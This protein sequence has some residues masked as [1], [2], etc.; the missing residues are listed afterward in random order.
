[1]KAFISYSSRNRDAV[2]GLAKDLDGAL[3]TISPS[4]HNAVWFD[5]ALV[6]GQDWWNTILDHLMNCDV[7]VFALSPNSISS[8]ACNRE[9]NYAHELNKRILPI[10]ITG[11][12]NSIDLP[13][14]LQS[15]QWINYTRQD[16]VAYQ[17]LLNALIELPAPEPLPDPLPSPPEMPMSPLSEISHQLMVDKLDRE[18]QI[19]IFYK[20]KEFVAQPDNAKDA[21]R[22]LL[23]LKEHPD[24]RKSIAEDVEALLKTL[25]AEPKR[26]PER[27]AAV[28]SETAPV[29][30]PQ[31][32]TPVQPSQPAARRWIG[33]NGRTIGLVL[34]ALGGLAYAQIFPDCAYDIYGNYFCN[35]GFDVE[36]FIG[37][38]IIA[39]GIGWGVDLIWGFIKKNAANAT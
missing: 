15:R 20:L 1:M 31:E 4:T 8:D 13:T 30:P 23:R 19:D 34:G 12:L 9:L 7:F 33:L 27:P 18:Q 29:Q 28:S 17:Q 14:F 24:V 26:P 5:Q 21:H 36:L 35:T 22:L 3:N 25:P 11:E 38:V 6:G 39:V 37:F 16:K 2:Q 10:W 32:K